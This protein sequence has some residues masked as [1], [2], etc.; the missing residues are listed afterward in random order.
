MRNINKEKGK[1]S[2]RDSDRDRK[3]IYCSPVE[4]LLKHENAKSE[5]QI[6]Q[7]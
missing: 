2:G 6:L 1:E 4:E 7:E 5:M 3:R